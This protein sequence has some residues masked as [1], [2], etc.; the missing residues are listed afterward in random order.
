MKTLTMNIRIADNG[1]FEE[2]QAKIVSETSGIAG[3]KVQIKKAGEKSCPD[4]L[5]LLEKTDTDFVLFYSGNVQVVRN[6]VEK[7]VEALS[8]ASG[9]FFRQEVETLFPRARKQ[10]KIFLYF[11]SFVFGTDMLRAI[12]LSSVPDHLYQEKILLDAIDRCGAAVRMEQCLIHT[13]D[14]LENSTSLYE[15]QFD[16][17]WYQEDIEDFLL[18]YIREKSPAGKEVQKQVFY[19]LTLRFFMNLNDKEKF[20]LD[21]DEIQRFFLAV[22]KLLQYIDDDVI[23]ARKEYRKLPTSFTYLFLKEKHGGDLELSVVREK[24]RNRYF[25]NGQ[26]LES[27][28][29]DTRIQAVNY[30]ND[31]LTIDGEVRGDFFIDDME[32]NYHVL[33]NGKKVPVKKVEA[34]NIV[35][36]FGQAVLRFYQFSFSVPRK[37]MDKKT[38]IE[39]E[40]VI[41]DG[42]A[43][44]TP[45]ELRKPAARLIESKWSYYAFADRMLVK[46]GNRLIITSCRHTDILK[47][48]CAMAAKGFLNIKDVKNKW[49]ILFLRMCYW[50]TKNHYN[51]KKT[52]IFFDKLYKA[53]DNAEYLF[54]YCFRNSGE[55]N[56]YYIVNRDS[57]DYVRLRKR[58]GKH[59]LAFES[60]RQRLAVLHA[61][62]IFATHAKVLKLCGFPGSYQKYFRN[63]LK[64]RIACIQHGLTVQ[65][66]AQFQN[67]LKDNT[68]LY[69]CASKYEIE[70]LKRPIYG[71]HGSEL[72]LTG[73]PR[74]DGLI[75]NDQRKILITP[76]WRRN[77]VITGN[78]AGTAKEYNPQ[79][80]NTK[81]FEMYNRLIN[82]PRLI[83][84]AEKYGYKL[85]YLVHPTLSSQAG[86]FD[87]N[88]CLSVIPAASDVSYEKMLTE[89]SLMLT[90]YSGVQFDFAYMK[91]P[92]LY[93]HPQ[94]LP[95]HYEETVYQ[96]DTMGFGPVITGHDAVVSELCSYMADNCRMKEKY[97]KRVEEFFAYTDHDNCRRIYETVM[98]L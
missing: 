88:K 73:C 24:G 7:L 58:Y 45:L 39:F 76:T 29:V 61:D 91:K 35:K 53:G 17:R 14:I 34:Y 75:S 80:K 85:I 83:E 44:K 65:D 25:V 42:N 18:P 86:D 56:C 59:V 15:P 4:F 90:D 94:E 51:R 78:R 1:E 47:R 62:I 81:Y 46:N 21:E 36:A 20:T 22:R 55:A 33:I 13:C 93:Y 11:P 30:W 6:D 57:A 2:K 37:L 41:R 67:R 95:P 66:I 3:V 19:C 77:V 92:V 26:W 82:D 32:K 96:Y 84:T 54:D 79:F 70:N 38:V 28:F 69:F 74:Y 52:W 87:T 40:A 9:D 71:Y 23:A 60:F 64:A 97:V 98:Q 63:L 72:K 8:H 12:E 31:T 10:E 27:D 89:S 49:Q 16:K 68:S 5:E 48:E 50:L 43:V